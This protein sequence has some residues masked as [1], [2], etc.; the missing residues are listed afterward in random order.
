MRKGSLGPDAVCQRLRRF[1]P[2]IQHRPPNPAERLGR[3]S[4]CR[5]DEKTGT[6]YMYKVSSVDSFPLNGGDTVFI[7]QCPIECDRNSPMKDL[8]NRIEIDGVERSLVLVERNMPF[9]PI[10]AGELIGLRVSPSKAEPGPT[11]T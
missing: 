11:E 3:K 4:S 6:I 9:G 8:G 5:R 1:K 2:E 7:V 10:Q